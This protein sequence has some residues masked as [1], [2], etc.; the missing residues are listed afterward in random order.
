MVIRALGPSLGAAGVANPLADPVLE[1][2]DSN[3]AVVATNDN[4]QTTQG[5]ELEASG[6][7]PNDA[8]EAAILATLAAGRLYRDR[9]RP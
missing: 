3:G 8:E 7:A 1:L 4:W 6:L 5:P 9:E 2:H